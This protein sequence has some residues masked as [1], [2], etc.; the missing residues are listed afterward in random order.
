MGG[1]LERLKQFGAL[2]FETKHQT[3]EGI[4]YPVEVTANHVEFDGHEY[5]F[6]IA[7]DITERKRNEE[8][9]S[10]LAS[11]VESSGDAII[12]S[13]LTG[14]I[15]S[16]NRGAEDLYG[17]GRNEV[18]GKSDFHPHSARAPR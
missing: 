7:R 5:S 9:R 3:K 16:W 12:S 6:A 10:F 8:T 11:L 2:Q 1:K 15:V 17:L 13:T 4:V 14:E 18:T